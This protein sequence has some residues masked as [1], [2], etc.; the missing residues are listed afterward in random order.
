MLFLLVY[1]TL[2]Y[3]LI[4]QSKSLLFESLQSNSIKRALGGHNK[5]QTPKFFYQWIAREILYRSV[6]V[7]I[8]LPKTFW[9]KTAKY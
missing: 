3:D 2:R 5:V 7:S 8:F 4:K 1:N 6:K 9:L